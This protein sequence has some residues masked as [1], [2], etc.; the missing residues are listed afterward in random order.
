LAVLRRRS[1]GDDRE[2]VATPCLVGAAARTNG[3]FS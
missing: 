3:C 2:L 1:Q